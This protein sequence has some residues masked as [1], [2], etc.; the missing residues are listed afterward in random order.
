[1]FTQRYFL[2]LHTKDLVRLR[3]RG[4]CLGLAW[5]ILQ[6]ALY[7]LLFGAV[8]SVVNRTSYNDYI[9]YLF[10]GLV[11]WRFFDQACQA[12]TE[13]ITSSAVFTRGFRVPYVY[14]PASELGAQ[15]IDFLASFSVLLV[16]LITFRVPLHEQMVILPASVLVCVLNAA[17]AGLCLSVVFVFFRDIRPIVQMG[18][19]AALFSST[20]F[21]KPETLAGG[22]G[23]FSLMLN[24]VCHWVALF[25][26]PI[27]YGTWPLPVDWAVSLA[28]AF[29]LILLGMGLYR[30]F[31]HKFY[32]YF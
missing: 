9:V 28:S 20:V 11:P 7:L 6:P 19:M 13:S 24:P 8:F 26:K 18:L 15:F 32:F 5:N 29:A 10:A 14:F 1:L 31:R 12:M 25:Q 22:P 2:W 17:G 4:A 23:R 27:Y 16:L 3:F 30:S 21:F